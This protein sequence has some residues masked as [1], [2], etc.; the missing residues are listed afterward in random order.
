MRWLFIGATIIPQEFT[1]ARQ[2][3]AMLALEIGVIAQNSLRSLNEIAEHDRNNNRAEAL[4]MIT[5]ELSKIKDLHGRAVTLSSALAAMGEQIP[6]IKPSGART[7]AAEAI[8]YEVAMVGRL[9]SYNDTLKNLFEVLRQKL[10]VRIPHTNGQVQ[11]LLIQI[12]ANANSINALNKA[13]NDTMKRFD[14]NYTP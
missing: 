14:Q 2:R 9:I 11:E 12:N 10:S 5:R 13:F 8:S 6:N 4:L 3:G 1:D 7:I